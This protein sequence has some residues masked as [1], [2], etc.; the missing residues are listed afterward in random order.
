LTFEIAYSSAEAAA[1]INNIMIMESNDQAEQLMN[2]SIAAAADDKNADVEL[3]A[4]KS[5]KML[6]Q[7]TY[8]SLLNNP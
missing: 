2:S 7:E 6:L 8:G 4:L 1:S 3:Q 5:K